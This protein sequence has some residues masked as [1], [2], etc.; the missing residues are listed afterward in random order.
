MCEDTNINKMDQKYLLEL[1]IYG[2]ED[3]IKA[4][5]RL[6]DG[7]EPLHISIQ[8]AVEEFKKTVNFLKKG[9]E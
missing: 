3:E 7:T 9:D 5:I 8:K 4:I 2:Q 1:Y 6:K